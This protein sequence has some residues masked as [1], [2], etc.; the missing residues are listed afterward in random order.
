MRSWSRGFLLM[1]RGT[2]WSFIRIRH[3]PP[4]YNSKAHPPPPVGHASSNTDT[5]S[6][7]PVMSSGGGQR[8]Q[9]RR[10]GV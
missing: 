2:L 8:A 10:P 1:K 3:G 6:S 7:D 5:S 4:T 9:R